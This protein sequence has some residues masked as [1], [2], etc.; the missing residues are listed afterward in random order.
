MNHRDYCCSKGNINISVTNS[1]ENIILSN[2]KCP[3]CNKIRLLEMKKENSPFISFTCQNCN[4]KTNNF[5]IIP[6]GINFDNINKKTYLNKSELYC[7]IHPKF[8]YN[9]YCFKCN[10]NI[11]EQCTDNHLGHGIKDLAS[12]APEQ[13]EVFVSKI[14]IRVKKEKNKK[15]IDAINS[16]KNEINKEINY[17]LNYLK[18]LFELEEFIVM[19]YNWKQPNK[20]YNYLQNFKIIINNLD[21]N[22][23][24]LNDFIN[25]SKF[26][27]RC[28]S[29][30]KLISQF[31]NFEKRDNDMNNN[32]NSNSFNYNNY[33]KIDSKYI[34]KDLK[35]IKNVNMNKIMNRKNLLIDNPC[36]NLDMSLDST[37]SKNKKLGKNNDINNM[38][39]NNQKT[40]IK[41]TMNEKDKRLINIDKNQSQ[42]YKDN[43]SYN[44]N[45]N[46]NNNNINNINNINIDKNSN[47]LINQ[48]EFNI[49]NKEN[50]NNMINFNNKSNSQIENNLNEESKKEENN[51]ENEDNDILDRQN[52]SN[53]NLNN[54]ENISN[55]NILELK[56][57]MNFREKINSIEF[58][59]K[60]H[61]LICNAH[62]L[63]IIKIN[64][65]NKY[66]KVCEIEDNGIG[67]N[68]A[69]KLKHG[70]IIVCCSSEILIYKLMRE[71]S[72][73]IQQRLKIKG[74]HVNKIIE[75]PEKN[76][77]ISCDK[78]YISKYQ[79]YQ[80]LQYAPIGFYKIDKEIKCIEYINSDV[81]A[82][83]IPEKNEIIFY[84]VDFIDKN[85]LIIENIH[86]LLGRYT[87]C[88]VNKYKCIFFACIFGIYLISNINFKLISLYNLKYSIS[89]I[90]Y[91]PYN[92]VLIC[93]GINN[94]NNI[95]EKDVDL[96]IF[97]I[98]KNDLEK[99]PKD[100][101]QLINKTKI[102]NKNSNIT[103]IN[104]SENLI[105]IGSSDNSMKKIYGY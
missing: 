52:N 78:Q 12:E 98:E 94:D 57:V 84:D 100:K 19:N 88:N 92:D 27:R 70:N 9:S 101:I 45:N 68:Y 86:A 105:L 81:F 85:Y 21:I 77:I 91:N 58:L 90:N 2:L 71:N 22:T 31:K 51:K 65:S 17:F 61:L 32:I 83:V 63:Y 55:N 89:S 80:N 4:V 14:K 46:I 11:C 1:N 7:E 60:T 73:N 36:E 93:G 48:S 24:S 96:M 66:E 42:S 28:N 8:I 20:N 35:R 54:E 25:D 16:I 64:S 62:N 53:N 34:P 18:N 6:N 49:I 99:K 10:K 37:I 3:N 82:S 95:N 72:K 56:K 76:L 23:P 97:S 79:K 43:D 87:I 33:Y 67:F 5:E 50:N 102:N 75:I 30:I 13:N 47:N 59:D 26:E 104:S 69:K 39:T 38:V 15:L 44:S 29:L 74:N 40:L 103:V 41:F